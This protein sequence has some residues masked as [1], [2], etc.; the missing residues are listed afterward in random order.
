MDANVLPSERLTFLLDLVFEVLDLLLCVEQ[1]RFHTFTINFGFF[2]N[3]ALMLLT[4]ELHQV[5]LD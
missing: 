5:E 4:S 2:L 1:E 3:F